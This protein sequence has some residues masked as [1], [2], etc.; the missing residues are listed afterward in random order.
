MTIPDDEYWLTLT[1]FLEARGE[2]YEG[3]VAVAWVI[4]NRWRKKPQHTVA[5]IVLQ[6]SQFSC[7]N[8]NSR[9]REAIGRAHKDLSWPSCQAAAVSAWSA[10]E[11]DDPTRGANHYLV[12]TLDPKPSWYDASRVTLTVGRHEFLRLS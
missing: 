7:F 9:A 4:C 2:P 6:P 8:T 11:E 1:V 10:K 3:Q 12:A 5:D